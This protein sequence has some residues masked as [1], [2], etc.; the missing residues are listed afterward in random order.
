MSSASTLVGQNEVPVSLQFGLFTGPPLIPTPFGQLRY[1][2]AIAPSARPLPS[3]AIPPA[4][5]SVPAQHTLNQNASGVLPDLMDQ[6]TH[7]NVPSQAVSSTFT[8][9][10]PLVMG[11]SNSQY[12]NG[13]ANNQTA[14]V[15]GFHG[16]VDRQPIGDTT[17]CE[18][19]QDLSLKRNCRPTS[20]DIESSQFGLGGRALNGPKAP[21]AVSAGRGRRYGYAVKD[22]N[23]RSTGSV[24]EPSHKDSRG[25]LQRRARRNVRRT[26]FRVRENIEKNQNEDSDSFTHCEQDERPYSNG[27]AR[28]F[29]VRNANRREL[30]IDKSSRV[31]EAS[32]QSASFRS[33]HKAHYERSHGGN[34]KS[35]TGA[36]PEGAVRVVKQ[37]GIEVPVDADGFIEVRSKRQIMNVR[38]EQ[39]EK[40]N[41][42][43][44]RM[45]KAP[46]KQHNVSLQS[47]VAPSVNKWTAPLSGEVA[48]K[49]SSDCAITV[50]GR[51]GDYAESS[52]ALKGDTAS[53]N[54]IGPPSTNAET[55]ANCYANQPI[56]IQ[57]SSDLVTS[58]P[59]AKLVSGL[60]EDNN[61]GASISTPF[62][63]V[64]WDNSQ[65]NQQVMPLTQTQL[66]EAMRPAK[67]EQQAGSSFS[68]ESNNA[69]S[70]T[71]TTEKAFPSSASPINSLLAGEKI[72]FGA[73]TSPTMLP[74][75]SRT[76]SSGLGA[77]GS[78]RPDM[79]IDRGLPS[80]NSGPDKANSKELCPNT[81][82]VEAEAE[83]AASAVA[84]AAI[85]TDEGSPADATTASAPDNKSFSSKDLSGLTSGGAITGQAGQSSTEEPLSVA[86]P[87]DLSVDTPS[88]SLWPPLA[89]P[90]A[91]GPMLSQFHGAQPSHFSCFDMN[92]MLG[93][94]IFA[95]GPSDESAGSQGGIP[96]V[97]GPPHMVVYNH[98]A[99]VGQ[100]GQM[101]LG[102]MGATYIPGDK[103]PDW[104]QSQGPPVVGHL[105]PTS[106]MPI[107][108]PLTMFDIAPFQAS[109][110]IQMQTC[111]PHMPV[112]P[113][114]SVPLS[115]QLQQHPVEATA[116]QQFVHNMPVDNKASTNNRFQEPSA[117]AV[118]SDSNKTFPNAAA[119]QFTDGLG[120][121]RQPTSSS[122]SSQTVQSSSFGQAG[123]ISDEVSTSAKVMVRSTPSKVNP[124]TT[125]GV[126]SNPNGGQVTNITPKTHQSSLSSD[127]QYQHPVNNQDRRARAIQKTGTGN[128]WH[129]RSGYQGRNQGS[130]SDRSSGTGRMKQI[131]VA[132]PS[133]TSGHAPSG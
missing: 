81:S 8:A 19:N 90:Q 105:R 13:P 72:Q 10:L 60:S 95:F 113:L 103:Q 102:F 40:E 65:I 88:M 32:D 68:L 57:G 26:E 71:V 101:G 77:P 85:S 128:E 100:F 4:H 63:M 118:P 29:S 94:H 79:K 87:A 7:Q 16:Q 76:V 25:G 22:I 45:T 55:N 130:G 56:Q 24:V 47:S 17:P 89:S 66:E 106:V 38:R 120:L 92:T 36:I 122:S 14:V 96:G 80:D 109:T 133:A 42:S 34:K 37:Q 107:P 67:F 44:M 104:K 43:K 5:S 12:L 31:N 51:I 46:R 11:N 119:S 69:L 125:A 20:N 117:S 114:H 75:V 78:S 62:N 35:R 52:V 49:V 127:Q 6:D 91:S 33:T 98:F 116:T 74:P 1:G 59:S 82:D 21:G 86:L 15:E 132:K 108:S 48:K 129:R 53:M 83:A 18:R 54:P 112:P 111:W 126:A 9:K 99:P 3:Q 50:E 131:Y 28:E 23:M 84:V 110:D 39:R 70:P 27:T 73:V 30:D 61:E 93:G 2:R 121:V 123:V 58:S 124:G 41:R 64:S 97:Q 115:V